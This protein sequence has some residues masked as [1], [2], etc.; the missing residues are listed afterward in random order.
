MNQT[1]HVI[2]H[3]LGQL[4][5]WRAIPQSRLKTRAASRS[6]PLA[7]A[8][9]NAA[10]SSL[11]T[12]NKSGLS[13]IAPAK[14]TG[15][16]MVRLRT[17]SG[18][19]TAMRRAIVAP[20]ECPIKSTGVS[21]CGPEISPRAISVA[22]SCKFPARSQTPDL[23]WLGRSNANRLRSSFSA[24]ATPRHAPKWPKVQWIAKAR[25]AVPSYRCEWV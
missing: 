6:S 2:A 20:K 18:L 8:A 21:S 15:S 9:S 7:N 17:S 3:P 25:R 12:R 23:P 19:S 4:V 1:R 22:T 13:C 11:Y 24:D 5:P 10:L 16:I 14:Y